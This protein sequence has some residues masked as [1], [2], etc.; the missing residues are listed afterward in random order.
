MLWD[1]IV[2]QLQKQAQQY[3]PHVMCLYGEES[4]SKQSPKNGIDMGV[5]NVFHFD[6]FCQRAQIMHPLAKDFYSRYCS[7]QPG[8]IC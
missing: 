4:P 6:K 8:L 2:L 3:W 7:S 1:N 5:L